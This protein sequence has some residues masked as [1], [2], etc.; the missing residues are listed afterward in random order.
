MLCMKKSSCTHI[1]ALGF[2]LDL[3]KDLYI[4][5]IFQSRQRQEFF[6]LLSV[7]SNQTSPESVYLRPPGKVS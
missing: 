4:G 1:A 6:F 7:I 5:I 2:D 3:D